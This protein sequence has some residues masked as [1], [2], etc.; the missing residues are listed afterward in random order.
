MRFSDMSSEIQKIKI[1]R[2]N[3]YNKAL[4]GVNIR[5]RDIN[6]HRQ[7]A[8]YS[9]FINTTSF[10]GAITTVLLNTPSKNFV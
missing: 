7:I 3:S 5:A 9:S 6:A 4:K 2:N 1:E 8:P 10:H